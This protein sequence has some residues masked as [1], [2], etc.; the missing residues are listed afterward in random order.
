[1]SFRGRGGR[2]PLFLS[3]SLSFDRIRS[4]YTDFSIERN[5]VTHASLTVLVIAWD[6]EK[7]KVKQIGWPWDEAPS[8]PKHVSVLEN[9]DERL[10]DRMRNV[11]GRLLNRRPD[12][13][14]DAK[15]IY[16]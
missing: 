16:N 13:D 15:R 2:R 10:G 8:G 3:L 4:C 11:E 6:S 14:T 1:M 12:T 7:Q 5:S 9:R